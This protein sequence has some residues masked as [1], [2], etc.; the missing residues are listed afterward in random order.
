LGFRGGRIEAQF[1]DIPAVGDAL[2]G[3]NWV[4]GLAFGVRGGSGGFKKQGFVPKLLVT[5]KL[6]RS[7]ASD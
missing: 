6:L 5:D 3:G 1:D 7:D 4:T 2:S